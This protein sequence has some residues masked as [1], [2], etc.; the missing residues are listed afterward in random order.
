MRKVLE[1]ESRK[2]ELRKRLDEM[3][4]RLLPGDCIEI[5]T[6]IFVGGDVLEKCGYLGK[7]PDYIQAALPIEDDKMAHVMRNKTVGLED[8]DPNQMRYLLPAGCLNLYPLLFGMDVTENVCVTM[9]AD[10][11][12]NEKTWEEGVRLAHFMV[13][14]V[15]FIG[16]EEYVLSSL[17]SVREGA[18]AMARDIVDVAR[19]AT[20]SDAFYPSAM[21][22]MLKK[23]Q[24]ANDV[25]QELLIPIRGKDVACASFNYH[26][27]T[28]SG[29]FEFDSEGRTVTGCVGFGLERFSSACNEYGYW[30]SV[31]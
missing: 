10:V 23:Y 16:S 29:K 5:G 22:N 9:C 19:V 6:D 3:C 15:V 21:T 2:L 26:E 31:P 14:E 24:I 25:K 4:V 28:F 12:R 17:E 1:R 27:R 8:L 11:F 30:P 20:A 7:N 18:L 13:R